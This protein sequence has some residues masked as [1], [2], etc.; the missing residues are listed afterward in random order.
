MDNE[1][2]LTLSL[3]RFYRKFSAETVNMEP[4]LRSVQV[5]K[6]EADIGLEGKD[7]REYVKQQ[8]ALDREERVTWRDAQKLQANFQVAKD[9]SRR[10]KAGK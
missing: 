7:V 4:T 9:A 10:K 6:Q 5:L 1:Q 2:I 3:G 8:Q